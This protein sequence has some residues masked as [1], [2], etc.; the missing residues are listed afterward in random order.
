MSGETFKFGIEPIEV[1]DKLPTPEEVFGVP[2]LTR[3]N[4]ITKVLGPAAIIL[5][6]SI[7]SGEWLMGPSVAARYGLF[8]FW[9]VW[10]GSFMQ[11]VWNC[12]FARITMATGESATRYLTRVPP[13]KWFWT[14]L[15]ILLAWLGWVW[16]GWA[17]AS[18][19]AVMSMA[20]G[21]IPGPEHA[22]MV[23]W[24]GVG[25]FLLCLLI[26]AIGYK[27]E[28]TLEIFNWV[29]GI[30]FTLFAMI[31]IIV[32]FTVTW[33][34]LTEA[35]QGIVSIGYIPKGVDALLLGGWW[36]YIGYAT[37]LN[38][39]TSG[40]YR[41]KGYG[42]GSMVGYIPAI[43]GGKKI[44]VSPTGKIFRLTKENLET[45]RR[46]VRILKY[47]QWYVFF[48]GALL[49]MFLPAL[50]VRSVTEL[51]TTLPAWGIA[52]HI[53]EQFAARVGP[54]GFYFVAFVGIACLLPTQLGVI[55]IL[56][57]T[58]T[59]AAW[60]HEGVRKFF[61]NDIRI[62]YYGLNVAYIIFASWAMWQTAPLIL[63]LIAANMANIAA[64]FYVPAVLYLNTK[65]PKE[66][67]PGLWEYIV[68]IIFWLM[69]IFIATAMILQ[70]F[71][72]ISI[73]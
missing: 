12:S 35:A 70:Q 68:L 69:C 27:I 40:Y 13:G 20:L 3:G 25:L 67:R 65:L 26:L 59:D 10:V 73:L 38:L 23:R 14:P 6:V 19:T 4:L 36:A 16:P 51:G 41:D 21:R 72:K 63:L 45:W 50:A 8:L 1:I 49:G 60:I 28:R 15:I 61:K 17:A 48:I 37:G 47:D 53:S 7:G 33:E 64:A 43:I 18:A 2:K 22:E 71:F 32:P 9:L 24:V 62:L 58:T 34:A 44:P 29:F 52:A 56:I 30:G 5:G 46:W 39:L 42:V 11:T 66:L 57:R 31:F 54:W 55:D